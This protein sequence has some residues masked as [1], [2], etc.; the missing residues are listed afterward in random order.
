MEINNNLSKEVGELGLF[1]RPVATLSVKFYD[2][3]QELHKPG[4]FSIS[5]T[6]SG[7]VGDRIARDFFNYAAKVLLNLG[8][9]D[10]AGYMLLAILAEGFMSVLKKGDDFLAGANYA[11]ERVDEPLEHRKRCRGYFYKN[12]GIKTKFSLGGEVYYAPMSVIAF[13][14]YLVDDLPAKTLAN[15]AAELQDRFQKAQ[16]G[17]M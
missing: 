17:I 3:P 9:G 1:S 7:D 10:E 4:E 15:V 11:I 14:Q 6:Y 16:A 2:E 12:R 13:M 8:R 5:Y